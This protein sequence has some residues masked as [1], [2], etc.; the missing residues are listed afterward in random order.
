MTLS[1]LELGNMSRRCESIQRNVTVS[2]TIWMSRQSTAGAGTYN[3]FG[4]S[5]IQSK[6]SVY[7]LRER[8]KY[9]EHRRGSFSNSVDMRIY[10]NGTSRAE[11]FLTSATACFCCRSVV[12]G[13]SNQTNGLIRITGSN[14]VITI[15]PI[16]Q[17]PGSWRMAAIR[18]IS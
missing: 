6:R 12:L 15:G 9:S 8:H 3:L 10:A 2:N 18:L 4:G 17:I 7:I 14:A 5:L 11:A 16:L 13:Q 1:T